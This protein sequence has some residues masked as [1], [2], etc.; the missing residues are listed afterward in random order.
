[1]NNFSFGSGPIRDGHDVFGATAAATTWNFAEGTTIRGFNEYLT[2]QNSNPTPTTVQLQYFTSLAGINPVKTLTLPA[3][4]RVTVEVFSGD[5]LDNP[6][7][8]PGTGGSCG[9]GWDIGGVSTQVTA[10]QPIVVERPMYIVHNFGTGLVAGAHVVVGATGLAQLFGFAAGSTVSGEN[11]FLTIQNPG[12]VAANITVTYYP[13]TGATIGRT[14]AVAA[15]SRH[16]VEVFAP[17][18]EGAG[19]GLAP[20]G[21]VVESDVPVLVE[22]P[23]YGSGSASYGATDTLGYT[24]ASF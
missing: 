17:T 19:P 8:T 1:M 6:S 13:P 10:S 21:M 4:S 15:G 9:V 5:R 18:A 24:P 11:D 23:T 2:L 20:L 16:T 12:N 7:C 14:F 3:T 22:K